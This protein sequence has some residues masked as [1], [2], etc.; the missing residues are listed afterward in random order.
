[1]KNIGI[2]RS[3]PMA[4]KATEAN[5]DTKEYPSMTIHHKAMP[6]MK[7]HNVGD[8]GTMQVKYKVTGQ[9]QYRSGEGHTSIDV[10]HGEI[11]P[12]KRVKDKSERDL[13]EES[14]SNVK[15]QPQVKQS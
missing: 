1:M 9:N 6:E 11:S 5:E 3:H 7:K 10:T 14:E 2:S 13:D 15:N 8:T 4:S 12:A